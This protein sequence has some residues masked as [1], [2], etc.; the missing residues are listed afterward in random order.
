MCVCVCV[1]ACARACACA[2][3][4]ACVYICVVSTQCPTSNIIVMEL[5]QVSM[6][7]N[8]NLVIFTNDKILQV[9]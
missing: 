7:Y 5:G 4:H 3:V 6:T 2:C 1:C 9:I 8:I